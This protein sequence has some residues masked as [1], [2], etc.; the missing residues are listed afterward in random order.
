MAMN[1]DSN[2]YTITFAIILVVIV[3]GLLALIANGLKPIQDENLKNEKK[4]YILNCLPGNKSITR[5]EAGDKFAEFVKQRLILNYDGEVV[6]N[7]LLNSENAVDDKNPNDAFSV[8]LLKEYKTIKDVNKRNYPLFIC[9]VGQKT[10]YVA[11]VMGKGLWAAVWGFIALDENG[12]QI[13]GAVF[14]HKSETPGLGAEITQDFFED[15]FIGKLISNENSYRPVEVNKP[16]NPLNDYQVDGISGG[17][18]TSVGV[19]EM[20]DRTLKVY[21][22]YIKNINK[23]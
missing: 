15:Q 18:F 1:K 14:D 17:T 9:K 20:M 10:Y 13:E 16:G 3:G 5:D 4:Q 12:D 11:P 2:A 21:H 22:K 8:D 19:E 7:T 6:N 23:T